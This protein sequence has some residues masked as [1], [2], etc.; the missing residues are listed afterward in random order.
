MDRIHSNAETVIAWLGIH[1][2]Y[3]RPAMQAV[4]TL[5]ELPETVADQVQGF[6]PLYGVLS[7]LVRRLGIEPDDDLKVSLT[8]LYP[9][10]HRTWFRRAWI[11]Q[12]AVLAK[13][14]VFWAETLEI[15]SDLVYKAA[16]FLRRS[17]WWPRIIEGFTSRRRYGLS[18]WWLRMRGPDHFAQVLPREFVHASQQ[19]HDES[20]DPL[21][22][23]QAVMSLRLSLGRPV[24]ARLSSTS[25]AI[26]CP[27]HWELL[28]QLRGLSATNPRDKIYAFMGLRAA[29]D[30]QDGLL[31]DYSDSN[32]WAKLYTSTVMELLTTEDSLA[33]LSHK[34]TRC[35]G[36]NEDLPSWVPDLR[37]KSG[38]PRSLFAESI[39]SR[40][41]ADGGIRTGPVCIA[42]G[43]AGLVL[44]G[45]CVDNVE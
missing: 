9:L 14:L 11:I 8:D 38:L 16:L 26:A 3:L 17:G 34:E 4:I 33:I 43:Q 40:W 7:D 39:E 12:E 18:P 36:E 45:W 13:R 41:S 24:A 2:Y 5:A 22:T 1:D 44:R 32:G 31:P 6:D 28:M 37:T 19:D 29:H 35:E 25:Q 42:S 30:I 10:L 23:I 20:F 21:D 15:P 27:C